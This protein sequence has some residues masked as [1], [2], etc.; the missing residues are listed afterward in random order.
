VAADKAGQYSL[1]SLCYDAPRKQLVFLN[2]GATEVPI[3][4]ELTGGFHPVRLVVR[5]GRCASTWTGRCRSGP[6]P[7]KSL[8]CE[9]PAWFI[10][11]PITQGQRG[12]FAC[13]WDYVGFTDEGSFG[14]GR[15]ALGS[16]A[17]AA[18]RGGEPAT[19]RTERGSHPG[20]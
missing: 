4:A 5:A 15:G 10:L 19:R 11:G 6:L 14:P 8:A 7:V 18:S 12:T 1:L 20:V 16:S 9:N 2:G 13:Q 3:P 17:R